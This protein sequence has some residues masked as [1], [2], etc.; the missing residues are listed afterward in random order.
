MA[1]VYYEK[2]IALV[3]LLNLNELATG[4]IEIKHFFSG[5]TLTY[6]GVICASLSPMGLA[7]KLPEQEVAD[8]INKEQAVP[9]K[10]F[11]KGNIKKGFA[12]FEDPQLD[13]KRWKKYFTKA[14]HNIAH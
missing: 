4:S 7:F 2:L 9:L 14:I 12:L 1:K 11:A 8:L 5:A 10:Y 3:D 6:N 13:S